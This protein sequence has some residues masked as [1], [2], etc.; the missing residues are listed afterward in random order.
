MNCIER[1]DF[2]LGDGLVA[3]HLILGSLLDVVNEK[4]Y[5]LGLMKKI[6]PYSVS[7]V[8]SLIF[9]SVD[10]CF[11]RREVESQWE[12]IV[13]NEPK[14]NGNDSWARSVVPVKT[15]F[16]KEFKTQSSVH[17]NSDTN[18]FRKNKVKSEEKVKF[19]EEIKAFPIKEPEIAYD[20]HEEFLRNK[21]IRQE[22]LKNEEKLRLNQL[23]LD[24]KKKKQL[25]VMKFRGKIPKYTHGTDGKLIFVSPIRKFDKKECETVNYKIIEDKTAEF[26]PNQETE[27]EQIKKPIFHLPT[28]EPVSAKT[29]EY[30]QLS[31]RVS[32]RRPLENHLPPVKTELLCTQSEVNLKVSDKK[33]KVPG[34]T[35]KKKISS[36]KFLTERPAEK[37]SW[38]E[39]WN[40]Q[41]FI[42]KSKE[43][44]K[45]SN[46][47][48]VD[49]FNLN[50]LENENWGAN[51][52]LRI[53]KL[54]ARLPKNNTLKDDWE[55]F[56]H[57]FKKPKDKLFASPEELMGTTNKLKKPKDRRV[58][59]FAVK[60]NSGLKMSGYY[61]P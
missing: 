33:P 37:K 35:L 28:F 24:E 40:V 3:S 32:L 22:K 20:P 27:E 25:V 39:Q 6:A 8:C 10:A 57:I 43:I 5:A 52:S 34:K 47:S 23:K 58:M 36:P 51:P 4:V 45:N 50:I 44:D 2:G 59:K 1:D 15:K 49:T 9:N 53:L 18:I 46:L 7:S 29:L 11:I 48:P 30:L 55:V 14:A 17:S 31:P 13:E 56:G 54:P 38:K 60:S 42:K 19:I 12:L 16:V 26:Q 21:K 41:G 61:S